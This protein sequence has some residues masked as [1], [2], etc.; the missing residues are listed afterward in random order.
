[1]KNIIKLEEMAMLGISI[2]LLYRMDVAW[3]YYLIL[4]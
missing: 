4:A 1:M 2:F 3:W